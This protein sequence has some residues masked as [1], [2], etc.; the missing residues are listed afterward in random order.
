MKK[1][2]TETVSASN[3]AYRRRQKKLEQPARMTVA[4]LVHDEQVP[5]GVRHWLER[6]IA[7]GKQALEH[8]YVAQE[9]GTMAQARLIFDVLNAQGKETDEREFSIEAVDFVEEY[10][11][12]LAQ[13]S[14]Q[15]VWNNGEIAVAALPTLLDFA[16]NLELDMSDQILLASAVWRLTTADERRHFLRDTEP[17]AKETKQERDTQ[18]GFKLARL[19][20]DPRTDEATR[21]KLDS[22]L[23]E[24]TGQANIYAT[25]PALARRSFTLA[26]DEMSR[27]RRGKYAKQEAAQRRRI[28]N[29]LMA[30]LNSLEG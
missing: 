18:A 9:A 27:R 2:S 26:V 12:R 28:Y 21:D 16:R 20:A 15:Q 4:D 13:Q 3:R 29:D 8:S 22:A 24:F 7:E 19:L 23:L 30:L 6:F 10:L 5:V 25:H 11:F 17:A 14:E 1:S